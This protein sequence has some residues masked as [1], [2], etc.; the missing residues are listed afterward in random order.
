M[1]TPQPAASAHEGASGDLRLVGSAAGHFA[2]SGPLTF[3]TA[4]RARE[5]GL[6][7][8][9]AAPG[10]GLE[11]DCAGITACDSAGL[12]VLL[13]WLGTARHAGRKLRYTQLPAGIAALARIS[14]VE[15]LLVGG[16]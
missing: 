13:D 3:A 8:F 6:Q 15:E 11:I 10:E 5:L 2:A 14:E 7:A 12:A 9:A 16:A 4:R 1:S